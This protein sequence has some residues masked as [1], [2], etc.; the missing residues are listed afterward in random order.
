M[1]AFYIRPETQKNHE[2]LEK[3]YGVCVYKKIDA[4]NNEFAGF[5]LGG[6]NKARKIVAKK[7][8]KFVANFLLI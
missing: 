3:I 4:Y 7:K 1:E 8:I 6:A 2:N 5:D